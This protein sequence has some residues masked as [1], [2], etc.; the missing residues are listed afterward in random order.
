MSVD[1]IIESAQRERAE[2]EAAP[3]EIWR[4]AAVLVKILG[5]SVVLDVAGWGLKAEMC[6]AMIEASDTQEE[7]EAWREL[8]FMPRGVV[9]D[10]SRVLTKREAR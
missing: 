8:M 3:I 5:P 9:L 4:R 7:T 6:A 2:A 10:V 1:S